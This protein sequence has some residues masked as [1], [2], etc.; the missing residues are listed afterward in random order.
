MVPA[1][2]VC[3][4]HS[5]PGSAALGRR[6]NSPADQKS[7]PRDPC[8]SS[9][10]NLPMGFHYDGQAGLEL[11]TSGDPPTS[12]SQSARI[13]GT[14]LTLSPRLECSGMIS[15]HCNFCIL[16]SSN[17]PGQPPKFSGTTGTYHHAQLIFIKC[18]LTGMSHCVQPEYFYYIIICKILSLC[19][20][21]IF[22]ETKSCSVPRLECSGTISI[23]CNRCLWVKVI[24]FLQPPRY[25]PSHLANFSSFSRDVVS[26]CWLAGLK[27]LTSGDPPASASQSAKITGVSHHIGHMS[28]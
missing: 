16:G 5:A 22:F 19:C 4:V 6:Q 1:E 21:Q 11:L 2:P 14:G 3:P 15:A 27:L 12:A 9:A 13:T 18:W 8:V 28:C 26:Q 23:H 17:F 20:L 7:R 25:L 10:G 24:L